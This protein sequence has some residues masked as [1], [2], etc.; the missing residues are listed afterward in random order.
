MFNVL[1]HSH[2]TPKNIA[3]LLIWTEYH[4]FGACVDAVIW[5]AEQTCRSKIF[6]FSNLA[7]F[8]KVGE[9]RQS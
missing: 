2:L 7:P 3:Y 5:V 6:R 1:S 4:Y 8:H 9:K